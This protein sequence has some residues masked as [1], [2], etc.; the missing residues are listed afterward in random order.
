MDAWMM[1]STVM[2]Q[3][4]HTWTDVCKTIRTPDKRLS[5]GTACIMDHCRCG[6]W[7]NQ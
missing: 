6:A 7:P 1:R 3:R 5:G 2:R 4:A